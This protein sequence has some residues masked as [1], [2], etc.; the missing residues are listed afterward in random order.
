M[1]VVGLLL[2]EHIKLY[3]DTFG[4]GLHCVSD[5]DECETSKPCIHTAI[6]QNFVG[7]FN[8]SCPKGFKGDGKKYGTGCLPS[9]EDIGKDEQSRDRDVI[10]A[11]CKYIKT[12]LLLTKYSHR[13][14]D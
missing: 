8:C 9:R 7:G 6:C 4:D 2:N 14:D 11:L 3:S 12:V 1:V 5:I 10:I 13:L